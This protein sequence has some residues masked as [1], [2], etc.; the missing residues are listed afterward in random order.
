MKRLS[1][2]LVGLVALGIGGMAHGS[3][4]ITIDNPLDLN[5]TKEFKVECQSCELFG[6]WDEDY[7]GSNVFSRVALSEDWSTAWDWAENP[8]LA[9]N[10]P[11][12]AA[13]FLSS[14][15][16][17]MKAADPIGARVAELGPVTGGGI[18]A[19]RKFEDP[20]G[21]D[22]FEFSTNREYFWVKAGNW[23]AF[24]W[25]PN[26]GTEIAVSIPEGVSYYGVAGV[27]IPA[28]FV[29]FGSGLVGLGWLARRQ[30]ARKDS[31]V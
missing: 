18:P 2:F 8:R 28:A 24:F 5:P 9:S 19:P 27:P 16:A 26:P 23:V 4:L 6:F 20:E 25:N 13:D 31:V 17:A 3:A 14:M 21:K 29:L 10:D 12:Q 22:I 15:I 30:R 1:S 7:D 11:L